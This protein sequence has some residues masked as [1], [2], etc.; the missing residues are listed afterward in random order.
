MDL[1][2]KRC[3]EGRVLRGLGS[4]DGHIPGLLKSVALSEFGFVGRP[5]P[6]SKSV[7]ILSAC[8]SIVTCPA[9]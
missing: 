3:R 7:S 8:V 4:A 9:F 6:T 5:L 2:H 1:L